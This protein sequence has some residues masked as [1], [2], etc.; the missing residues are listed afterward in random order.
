[1]CAG[2]GLSNLYPKFEIFDVLLT[3]VGIIDYNFIKEAKNNYTSITLKVI[4]YFFCFLTILIGGYSCLK[5]WNKELN[6]V[7]LVALISF[8]AVIY[9]NQK[10]TLDLNNSY[11]VVRLSTISHLYI[12]FFL[13]WFIYN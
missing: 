6:I 11:Q 4:S 10:F 7:I 3:Q 9:F 12:I 5:K 8:I 2:T 1:M 13:S